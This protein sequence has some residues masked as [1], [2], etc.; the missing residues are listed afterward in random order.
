MACVSPVVSP[1]QSPTGARAMQCTAR[2]SRCAGT[3][4]RCR[5][6]CLPGAALSW[7]VRGMGSADALSEQVSVLGELL[8]WTTTRKKGVGAE[9]PLPRDSLTVKTVGSAGEIKQH[10]VAEFLMQVLLGKEAHSVSFNTCLLNISCS[11]VPVTHPRLGLCDHI[12]QLCYRQPEW[13]PGITTS[14]TDSPCKC[15]RSLSSGKRWS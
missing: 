6:V 8:P 13:Q 11:L 2:S 4:L 7:T 3:G 1:Q 15:C 10:L 12:P 9:N 14:F 5:I